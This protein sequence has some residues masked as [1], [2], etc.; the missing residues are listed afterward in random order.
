MSTPLTGKP[1]MPE[2]IVDLNT[3][4]IERLREYLNWVQEQRNLKNS[5]LSDYGMYFSDQIDIKF[6]KNSVHLTGNSRFFFP[7]KLTFINQLRKFARLF[8]IR[9]SSS[10][11]SAYRNILLPSIWNYKN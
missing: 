8:P 1:F 6:R 10:V 5:D 2:I 3:E 7:R 9:F 11:F 4:K